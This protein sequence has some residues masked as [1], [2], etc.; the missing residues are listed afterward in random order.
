MLVIE[1]SYP[2][3]ISM[4]SAAGRECAC[5]IARHSPELPEYIALN[6]VVQCHDIALQTSVGQASARHD[7]ADSSVQLTL[8]S[9]TQS[10]QQLFDSARTACGDV[11]GAHVMY[12][13][14]RMLPVMPAPLASTAAQMAELSPAA[15]ALLDRL[16]TRKRT[17]HMPARM[18]S[19]FDTAVSAIQPDRYISQHHVADVLAGACME[20]A[21]RRLLVPLQLARSQTLGQPSADAVACALEALS[22]AGNKPDVQAVAAR[23]HVKPARWATTVGAWLEALQRFT[24]R[25][26]TLTT[27]S[28]P[29]VQAVLAV[30][31]EVSAELLPTEPSEVQ[32]HTSAVFKR[33]PVV[34]L[35]DAA[36]AALRFMWHVTY[37]V[38]ARAQNSW[39]KKPCTASTMVDYA[40][41]A[42]RHA[43]CTQAPAVPAAARPAWLAWRVWQSDAAQS[44]QALW[45][46]SSPV[47]IR[48]KFTP[49]VS[50]DIH[51][52]AFATQ[53]AAAMC[54]CSP[55]AW[56][57][58]H[59]AQACESGAVAVPVL[60]EFQ[61]P[62]A[63]PGLP[64]TRRWDA[65][66]F[67]Q[68]CATLQPTDVGVLAVR[69][70]CEYGPPLPSLSCWRRLTRAMLT[71]TCS[72]EFPVVMAQL[73]A[74]AECAVD[75]TLQA[76]HPQQAQCVSSCADML[77]SAAITAL[78]AVSLCQHFAGDSHG[79]ETIGA[80]EQV[81]AASSMQLWWPA[82]RV[83][84]CAGVLSCS[85]IAF[86]AAD[87]AAQAQP[88][89]GASL[90]LRESFG[91]ARPFAAALWS[92]VDVLERARLYRP[93]CDLLRLLLGTGYMRRRRGRMWLRLIV[94]L[95]HC[96]R[97]LE[98]VCAGLAAWAD[99]CVRAG[100]RVAL[101][102]RFARDLAACT[103]AVDARV[104]LPGDNSARLPGCP[105]CLPP[106][107]VATS[108]AHSCS[109][110]PYI[111]WVAHVQR[112]VQADFR[113]RALFLLAD[114][115]NDD[116]RPHLASMSR[117]LAPTPAQLAEDGS[118]SL[119]NIW[120]HACC[121]GWWHG[122]PTDAR[123][124]IV[125]PLATAS[126][127]HSPACQS[128][129][130]P[131]HCI[132]HHVWFAMASLQLAW[133]KL[134]RLGNVEHGLRSQKGMSNR[135]SDAVACIVGIAGSGPVRR[136]WQSG[137]FDDMDDLLGWQSEEDADELPQDPA[138]WLRQ[139][140]QAAREQWAAGLCEQ[141][142]CASVEEL[143]RHA[144]QLP[145]CAVAGDADD[146]SILADPAYQ[147]AFVVHGDSVRE[148]QGL[149]IEQAHAQAG[150]LGGGW[151]GRHSEGS[152]LRT[153]LTLLLWPVIWQA[154]P[155]PWRHC[156]SEDCPAFEVANLLAGTNPVCAASM[157][158][159]SA[160][161]GEHRPVCACHAAVRCG[162]RARAGM[163]FVKGWAGGPS[164]ALFDARLFVANRAASLARLVLDVACSNAQQLCARIA[165]VYNSVC[166]TECAGI[167]WSSAGLPQ[168]QL[169]AVGLS[170][171]SLSVLLAEYSRAQLLLHAGLPD[172]TLWRV[173]VPPRQR[174][175]LASVGSW[176]ALPTPDLRHILPGHAAVKIEVKFVEVKSAQDQLSEKQ[177][178]WLQVFARAGVAAEVA[179]VCHKSPASKVGK[180][181]PRKL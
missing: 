96:G 175:P 127:W 78:T 178:A 50:A 34:K 140:W 125:T 123:S 93:A 76:S 112:P 149:E 86:A 48:T 110:R 155:T 124:H 158:E 166:D 21:H 142:A 101:A 173:T 168:L 111:T 17:W 143:V 94:D 99:P 85:L 28:L 163:L 61:R 10:E 129:A 153:L 114:E 146:E 162:S 151:V 32:Q 80:N 84:P 154:S 130:E 100:S 119:M 156:A 18:L 19:S 144:Y 174:E 5:H 20:L 46:E 23:L 147:H 41:Q 82:A 181:R 47:P 88:T 160:R 42:I 74:W 35:T 22:Q 107:G 72:H 131:S 165:R 67:I 180:K 9:T 159:R 79:A 51:V 45:P 126:A 36:Q 73:R 104:L 171:L 30:L 169:L 102:R 14:K 3:E 44:S 138:G 128:L 33:W 148:V 8:A 108:P 15:A 66:V 113:Q 55:L 172:L 2:C 87:I 83:W 31:G 63:G 167:R 135:G 179:K 24:T 62:E 6:S 38:P 16:A 117:L 98:A 116:L 118:N 40:Q 57:G 70:Q 106:H 69:D 137:G 4:P 43:A 176:P 1:L 29:L 75:T 89:R 136:G 145:R 109:V 25:Q 139:S 164:D 90:L 37:G 11:K 65:E 7:R 161:W 95:Q 26:T 77:K 12:L 122:A 27:S 81:A 92:L 52:S 39:D 121:A 68:V 53:Q 105:T 64:G 91:C 133:R 60:G 49:G 120:Q 103:G 134:L 71:G 177:R 58:A 56:L 13:A 97:S 115:D 132:T 150:S 141:P 170:G 152:E 54:A 59:W 157:Q